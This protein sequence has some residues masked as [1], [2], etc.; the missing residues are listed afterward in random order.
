MKPEDK[1]LEESL[2]LA[3]TLEEEEEKA[4]QKELEQI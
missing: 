2:A 3:K 1:G 4:S